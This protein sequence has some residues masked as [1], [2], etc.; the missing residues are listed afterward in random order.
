MVQRG[1]FS[2]EESTGLFSSSRSDDL[3]DVGDRQRIDGFGDTCR[4][5]DYRNSHC[6]SC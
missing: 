1:I 4:E 6:R 2:V 3:S 5:E